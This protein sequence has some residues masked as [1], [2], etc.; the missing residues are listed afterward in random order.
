MAGAEKVKLF[1]IA[2]QINIGKDAIVQFLQTKGF[3]VE[4]K[5]TFVLS[6]DMTQA[7]LD[8]FQK[9]AKAAEKQREKVERI[10]PKVKKSEPEKSKTSGETSESE[11]YDAP[12]GV[13]AK[14]PIE[15]RHA[16]EP[17]SP[18][19]SEPASI[20]MESAIND[21]G[22][23][24]TVEAKESA[25]INV[26]APKHNA[27]SEVIDAKKS[28]TSSEIK[29]AD[30]QYDDIPEEDNKYNRIDYNQSAVKGKENQG[31]RDSRPPR[32][33]QGSRDN[34]PPRDGQAPRDSRPPREGGQKTWES[35][36]PR[37]GQASGDS[38][39]PREG[40]NR[41]WESRPPR[42]GQASGEA[43]PPREG[44]NRNWESRPPRDGQASGDSRP[45]REGGNRNWE[46]RP[47]RDGQASGDSR[48][49]REGGNRNWES[50]PPR[51][52]QASG[53][54]RPPREGGNRNWESR[55]P[56]DGQAGD[57]RPPREG[58]GSRD[59]RPPR[60][61]QRTWESR[62]P[63]DGQA[64]DSRPPREGGNRNWESRPPRDGQASGDNR[65]PRD[66]QR[67]WE[68]RPPRDGQGA[69]EDPNIRRKKR[70]IGEIE[71]S[72]GSAPKLPGLTI[73]GKI[74][75][76]ADE[77]NKSKKRGFGPA[78]TDDDKK[79][80]AARSKTKG[81]P[82]F[83]SKEDIEKEKKKKR[84]KSMRE[85]IS[86]EE[87][88]KAIRKTLAG[89]DDSADT[90]SRSKLKQKK[91]LEREEKEA[92]KQEAIEIESTILRLTEFVSVS[93]LAGL[94]NISPSEIIVKCMSLGLMVS[95]NQ[96]LDKDTILL[97]AD[98]YG[99]QVEFLDSAEVQLE[100]DFE[101]LVE[102]LLPRPPIVTIMGHVDHGK[103]SLLDFIRKANVV[104]GEAGGIT[105]HI[106]AY[107]VQ[108]PKRKIYLVL[109]YSGSR[110]LYSYACSW[111]SSN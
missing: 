77:K 62:P 37:D 24:P 8:K 3:D 72:S 87:I 108:L 86:V 50:R 39:P 83:M 23:A 100:D 41:N 106:G 92:K 58:Q 16:E 74:E 43:R 47:P 67:T 31:S 32:D 88:D 59:S 71:Y 52:G 56:R 14:A 103:T 101:D 18:R 57:S 102:D 109:R 84:K 70:R 13:E 38:R 89:M 90:A 44:G 11:S 30:V 68:N 15:E 63:R 80:K 98:D 29:V 69:S 33:N 40:G 4:N 49:P 34:R 75:L 66:G 61:G 21:G 42:D 53:D 94:I 93:D 20:K 55:P 36:P 60:D 12:H 79:K 45:P 96:R 111:S 35:R 51:D 110:S 1:K 27:P 17:A 48:P 10:I 99:L 78:P 9:E 95:I 76:S 105:Q 25:N 7:V 64:G 85:S 2:S 107:R 91:R 22:S 28:N 81:K 104:A 82:K 65:P 97:I 26:S 54:S 6:E 19:K 46:S 5:P 73:V